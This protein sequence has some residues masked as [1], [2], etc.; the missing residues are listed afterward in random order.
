MNRLSR[1]SPLSL[2]LVI[3]CA[4]YNG[5][6]NAK[7]YAKQAESSERNGRASEAADRWRI[8]AIHAES[9]LARH[10]HSRWAVEAMLIRTKAL[11]HLESWSDAGVM[12]ERSLAAATTAEDR[13]LAQFYLGQVQLGMR[14]P[15]DALPHLDS[16]VV[17]ASP[18]RRSAA[19][20][21]RGRALRRLGRPREALDDFRAAREED[22]L[23]E[24]SLAALAL[25]DAALSATY[26]DTLAL[27]QPFHETQWLLLLDSLSRAGAMDRAAGL[28]D[29]VTSRG[30]VR[31]GARAR[32]L[33]AE[34]DRRLAAGEDSLAR[35]RYLA[36]QR[37]VP[38]SV[39]ARTASVRLARID[40]RQDAS[41]AGFALARQKLVPALQG[42]GTPGDEARD[43][44][45]LLDLADTL[46]ARQEN[47]DAFWFARAELLRDSLGAPAEAAR[48][49]AAMPARFPD[50]PWTPKAILAAIAL[51]SPGADSLRALLTG[52]YADN[53]YTLAATGS[54]LAADRFAVLEDSLGG[55]I[56]RSHVGRAP[57]DVRQLP[58]PETRTRQNV[59]PRVQ[60]RPGNRPTIEP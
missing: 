15:E 32:L 45:R 36:V 16:A 41:A 50:S 47:P 23:Y 53:P 19:L 48:A 60:P 21:A 24:R 12:A 58:A 57:A 59:S 30:D 7:H 25:G 8:A 20:L 28:A 10:P 1:L 29:A 55:I 33:L 2:L 35:E 37:I 17:A 26:A 56:E 3:S 43:L 40:L 11:I 38:D 49:F 44:G 18:G 6:Y 54:P 31:N 22:A 4:Y 14:H 13:A 5:V 42:G 51:G 39:E 9:A 52:R 27:T 46:A 34:A